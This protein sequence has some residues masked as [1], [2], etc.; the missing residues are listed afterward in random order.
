MIRRYIL[1]VPVVRNW[2]I[3]GY[4]TYFFDSDNELYRVTKRGEI[5]RMRRS[6]KRYTI[7]YVLKSRFLS[8]SQLQPLLRLHDATDPTN[9]LARPN[10]PGRIPNEPMPK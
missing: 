5:K 1:Q 6:M 9:T 10:P 2:D 4:P 7:G 3:D 8:L